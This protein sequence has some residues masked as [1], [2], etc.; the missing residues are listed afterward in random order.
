MHEK[1]IIAIG[2]VI[3]L[4]LSI[5]I[6]WKL[7][8]CHSEKYGP[9]GIGVYTNWKYPESEQAC[10]SAF[11]RFDPTCQNGTSDDP[12]SCA[13]YPMVFCEGQGI[14]RATDNDGC[15]KNLAMATSPNQCSAPVMSMAGAYCRNG[16]QDT[17]GNSNLLDCSCQKPVPINTNN[18]FNA[19]YWCD[20]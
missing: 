18:P 17:V 2:L 10:K 6:L 1:D 12:Y 5:L 16:L 9:P 7:K 13:D 8:K 3:L 15:D 14:V 20:V 11:A 4:I 19:N